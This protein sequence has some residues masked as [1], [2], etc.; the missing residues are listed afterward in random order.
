ML[1]LREV[2]PRGE[3]LMLE[4]LK[5]LFLALYFF[6]YISTI[7][8]IVQTVIVFFLRTMLLEEIVSPERS[9][10]T[11]K[12][13]LESIA[14]WS[15]KWLVTMNATK[16]KSMTFSLKRNKPDHPVF[17]LSDVPIEEVSI[18]E[19]LG[20]LLSNNM[21]W[22]AHILRLHQRASK[23][24][25]PLKGLKFKLPRKTLEILYKSLVRAK[26]EY[27]DIVWDGCSQGESDV[28][29]GL[30]YEAAKVITGVMKGTHRFS[31]LNETG[32]LKMSRRREMHKLIMFYKM[33][34]GLSPVYLSA[35]CPPRVSHRT[36]YELRG[37]NNLCL[38]R[39]RTEILKNPSCIH[40]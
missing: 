4:Y 10:E 35:L 38:P 21:S 32:L 17:M 11:L 16:T 2:I 39:I 19:H 15:N 34:N 28:I 1:L 13:D 33:V 18:H 12:K 30:Q 24:L 36:L 9:A 14:S 6:G 29:E 27:A 8:R 23:Q 25:N 37:R 22:R 5:D 31:L 7:F 40:Q 26:M 20:L 3:K